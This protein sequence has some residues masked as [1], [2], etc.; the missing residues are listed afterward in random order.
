MVINWNN[1][2]REAISIFQEYLAIDTS[3]SKKNKKLATDFFINL[4]L[5]KTK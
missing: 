5:K 3:N 1:I 2:N 4:L